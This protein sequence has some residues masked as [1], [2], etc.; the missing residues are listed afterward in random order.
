MLTLQT[1]TRLESMLHSKNA[2]EWGE[3]LVWARVLSEVQSAKAMLTAAQARVTVSPP[4]PT[5]GETVLAP[6]PA[7]ETEISGY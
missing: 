3:F 5:V 7:T 4:P 2:P 6:P 1:L